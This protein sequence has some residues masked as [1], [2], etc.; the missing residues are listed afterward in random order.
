ML[1]FTGNSFS[2]PL[3]APPGPT[4][5]V[6]GGCSFPCNLSR[7]DKFFQQTLEVVCFQV[8]C[9]AVFMGGKNIDN[10]YVRYVIRL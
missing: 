2:R 10:R 8:T 3:S 9:V 1:C 4:R 7:L 5:Q 6:D